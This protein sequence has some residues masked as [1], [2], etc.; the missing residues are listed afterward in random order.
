MAA[1][2]PTAGPRIAG[3]ECLYFERLDDPATAAERRL[4]E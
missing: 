3:L 4:D 2:V 1:E